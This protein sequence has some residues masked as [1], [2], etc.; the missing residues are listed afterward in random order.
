MKRMGQ[1]IA[2]GG[3]LFVATL[4][5]LIL[6]WAAFSTVSSGLSNRLIASFE[7]TPVE[8]YDYWRWIYFKEHLPEHLV[9]AAIL[10]ALAGL[11]AWGWVAFVRDV[12]RNQQS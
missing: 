5:V 6:S 7:K 12:R 10:L 2:R 9:V 4:V 11:V 1:V 8:G 3:I